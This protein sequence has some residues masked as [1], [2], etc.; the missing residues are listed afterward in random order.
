MERRVKLFS[1]D[2]V[3]AQLL[4]P[5]G[6]STLDTPSLQQLWK[7][8]SEGNKKAAYHSHLCADKVADPW[9]VG[10][11]VSTTAAALQAAIKNLETQDMQRL[12]RPE[13]YD[14]IMAEA[15]ELK[16]ILEMLNIGKGS[17]KQD[18]AGGTMSTVRKAE[19]RMLWFTKRSLSG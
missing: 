3:A 8:T 11:G 6:E 12:V 9:H 18:A 19:P 2:S 10:A 17:Q 13:L 7:A 14:K 4:V 1:W 5:F 15:S 16:P